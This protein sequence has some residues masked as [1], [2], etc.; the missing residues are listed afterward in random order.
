VAGLALTTALYIVIQSRGKWF[1]DFE[2][3]SHGPHDTREAA[4][5]E[6]R[7]QAQFSAH[8]N[9]ASE[10]LVPDGEGKFWVVWSSRDAHSGTPRRVNA[11]A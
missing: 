7:N 5:L 6:A 1:V 10:V 4:A 2:G 11:A 9:R 8:M 3:R